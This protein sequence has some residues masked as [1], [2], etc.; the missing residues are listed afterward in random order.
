LQDT[1]CC[2][3]PARTIHLIETFVHR[4]SSGADFELAYHLLFSQLERAEV[5]AAQRTALVPLLLEHLSATAARPVAHAASKVKLYG[6]GGKNSPRF[7]FICSMS[8]YLFVILLTAATQFA[9]TLATLP[10]QIR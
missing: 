7:S 5:S 2:H 6:G 10:C 9:P 8:R 3:F 4:S 1:H